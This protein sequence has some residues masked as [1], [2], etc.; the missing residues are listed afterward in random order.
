MPD[1]PNPKRAHKLED[2]LHGRDYDHSRDPEGAAEAR[3]LSEALGDKLQ[4]R[5]PALP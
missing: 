3:A 4:A 2:H 1:K 5:Q